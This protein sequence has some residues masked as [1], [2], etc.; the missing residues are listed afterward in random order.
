MYKVAVLVLLAIIALLFVMKK[1]KKH[2]MGDKPR[3]TDSSN[4][5]APLPPVSDPVTEAVEPVDE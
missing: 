3:M 4:E 5:P 1:N 2:P